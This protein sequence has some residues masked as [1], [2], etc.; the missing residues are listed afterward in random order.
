MFNEDL[1]LHES[2]LS[3]S[4]LN[5]AKKNRFVVLSIPPH[6]SHQLQPLDCT[7]YGPL[8]RHINTACNGLILTKSGKTMSIYDVPGIVATACPAAATQENIEAGFRAKGVFP[9]NRD[10][11]SDKDF[12]PS[13]VTDQAK[14]TLV[15]QA[16]MDNCVTPLHPNLDNAVPGLSS[17]GRVSP[18]EL[19]PFSKA[20]PRKVGGAVRRKRKMDTPTDTPM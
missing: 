11:F 8:K 5:Y 3:V 14:P 18:K 19:W 4:G 7:V 6:C 16:H 12:A 9:F 20:G 15:L 17:T 10:I 13:Y 1:L 2:H